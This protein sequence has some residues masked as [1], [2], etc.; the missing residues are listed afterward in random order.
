[1]DDVLVV[2]RLGLAAV[3]AVAGVAKL[4]DLPGSRRALAEFGAPAR[5]AAPGAVLLPLAELATALALLIGPT[6]RWGAVAALAL[7]AAFVFGLSRALRRGVAPDCHCFG[8]LH[9]EPASKATVVRNAILMVPALAVVADPG[10][11]LDAWVDARDAQE[12]VLVATTTAT[13]ALAGTMVLLWREIGR[14]RLRIPEPEQ[15]WAPPEPLAVGEPAPTF[16]AVGADGGPVALEDLMRPGRPC[17]L[18]FVQPG[19]GPCAELMPD[20]G[21]WQQSLAGDLALP[22]VTYGD[23]DEAKRLTEEHELRDV[24]SQNAGEISDAYKVYATPCA[25]LI[26]PDGT[27]GSGV[28]AGLPAIEALVRVALHRDDAPAELVVHQVA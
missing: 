13:L 27:I 14:L 4:M 20:L 16:S 18:T 6:A 15:A 23:V 21:R 12:L 19:C 11:A 8:Q 7:L 3:F 17:V 22:V 24:I 28:V 26:T 10:P 9:S 1:M 2:V 25:V 5:L